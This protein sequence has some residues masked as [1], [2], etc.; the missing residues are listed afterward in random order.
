M[1]GARQAFSDPALRDGFRRKPFPRPEDPSPPQREIH[2]ADQEKALRTRFF[3][4]RINGQG[5]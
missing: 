3:L 5:S 1:R 4:A 2:Q